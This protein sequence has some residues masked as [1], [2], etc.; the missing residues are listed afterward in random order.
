MTTLLKFKINKQE[1]GERLE[2]NSSEPLY[3]LVKTKKI[4]PNN[5]KNINQSDYEYQWSDEKNIEKNIILELKAVSKNMSSVELTQVNKYLR[6]LKKKEIDVDYGI[7]INFPQP[8]S[9]S[10]NTCIEF[11]VI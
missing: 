3:I 10:C 4:G 5:F 6:E 8:T 9:K 1:L 7:L 2:L 11:I